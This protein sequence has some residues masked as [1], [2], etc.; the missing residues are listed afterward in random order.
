MTAVDLIREALDRAY[1]RYHGVVVMLDIDSSVDAAIVE[2]VF[3][4]WNRQD[5]IRLEMRLDRLHDGRYV[6][7]HVQWH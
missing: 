3:S 2:R 1:N 7:S 6:M 5:T 4:E